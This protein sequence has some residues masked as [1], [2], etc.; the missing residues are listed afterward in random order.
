MKRSILA[1][2]AVVMVICCL[3]L[4]A[5]DKTNGQEILDSYIFDKADSIVTEDFVL[6]GKIGGQDATWSS[7][8]SA[9]TLSQR[10]GDWTAQVNYPEEGQVS[11]KLTVTVAKA[12]KTFTVRVKALDAYDFMTKYS[13]AKDKMTVV[14]NF[15]L[16]SEFTYKGK[17]ATITWSVDEDYALYIKVSED[18]KTLQVT[19]QDVQTLVEVKAHFTYKDE[20]AVKSYRMTVYKE[21]SGLEEVNYWYTNVPGASIT[22]S[23]YVVE[24]AT[25][26]TEQYKNVSFYMVNDEFTAGYYI[27]HIKTTKEEADKLAPGVH[28]TVNDTTNTS[29]SGVIETNGNGSFVV[30]E[31]VETID[32]NS[33]I[34][35]IDEEILGGLPSTIYSMSRLV[36]LTNWKVTKVAADTDKA[37]G[38]TF[39][40]LTLEKGKNKVNVQVAVSKYME[41]A[42]ATKADDATW[43]AL[44]N[45][46]STATVGKTVNVTGI[47]TRFNDTW[48]I[49]PLN[50]DGVTLSDKDADDANKE[51]YDGM[52]VATAMTEVNE[53]VKANLTGNITEDKEFSM[54]VKNGDVSIKYEVVGNS[55]AVTFNEGTMTVKPGNP[56]TA[57]ILVTYTVGEFE[58]VQFLHVSS[59]VPSAA[60]MLAALAVPENI[61]STTALPTAPEGATIEWEVVDHKDSLEIVD[62][63][64]VPTLKEK[65]VAVIIRATLTYNNETRTK[66]YVV[67]VLDNKGTADKPYTVAEAIEATKGLAKNEVTSYV[68]Y[69]KGVVKSFEDGKYVKNLYLQ[70]ATDS[71]KTF[72]V[73]SVSYNDIVKTIYAGDTVVVCGYVKNYNGTIEMAS[74]NGTYVNFVSRTIGQ[75]KIT[76]GE[77]GKAT[78]KVDNDLKSGENGTTFTFEVTV[79]NGYEIVAV[80]VNGVAV[81]SAEGKYTGTIAGETTITVET[82]EEGAKPAQPLLTIKKAGLQILDDTQSST[83]NKY[84]GDQTFG[85][86]TVNVVGVMPNTYNTYE[87][88]QLQGEKGTIKVT[89]TF[90]KIKIVYVGANTYSDNYGFNITVGGQKQ[91]IDAAAVNATKVETGIIGSGSQDNGK[92]IYQFTVELS[93]ESTIGEIMINNIK[94]AKYCTLIEL[95]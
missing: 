78:V 85:D 69:M 60:S 91:T 67:V 16:D 40:L 23:G 49:M 80:K 2:L 75:G 6:P 77:T 95:Y 39:T 32:V 59:L 79:E 31:D 10:D 54:P 93:F 9:I 44:C 94:G 86:Y 17:T 70:D 36:S 25:V 55:N 1:L 48:Q 15:A 53:F 45:L 28:V 47:L 83:Y 82:A 68:L 46:T 52:K 27:Y 64:L 5:C 41:G 84:K 12:S 38:K 37:A 34:H 58:A 76:I 13:F 33:K 88:V 57:T 50:A 7:D 43:T 87:V 92:A 8:N 73:Y 29:Y 81:T 18:G 66:D 71:T 56:E 4:A 11:V 3:T 90:T 30:D 72:L 35:P 22:M 26:W 14:E 63:K 51:D 21:M 62:G 24:V 65:N 20:T 19:P 89:G 42:Y 61:K 74:N